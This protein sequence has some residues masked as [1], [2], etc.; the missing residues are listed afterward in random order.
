M[1]VQIRCPA[2]ATTTCSGTVALQLGRAT[3][4]GAAKTTVLGTAR[5]TASPGKTATV[6]ITLTKAAKRLLAKKRKLTATLLLKDKA[7]KTI[8]RRILTLK[9]PKKR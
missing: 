3:G 1:A 5:Y 8:A 2:S 4:A 9:A 6:R 7:G